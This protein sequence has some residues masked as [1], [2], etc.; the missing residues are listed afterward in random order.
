MK[1]SLKRPS[2]FIVVVLSSL[3]H[4]ACVRCG[5]PLKSFEEAAGHWERELIK[6]NEQKTKEKTK[7]KT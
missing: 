5:T 4:G 3:R 6:S 2:S 1:H 7:A